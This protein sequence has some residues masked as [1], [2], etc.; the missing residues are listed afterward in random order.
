MRIESDKVYVY[1]APVEGSEAPFEA[2]RELAYEALTRLEL[3][4]PDEGEITLK[5]NATVLFPPEKRIITH[6]GF[7][8]GLIEALVEKGVPPQRMQVAELAVFVLVTSQDDLGGIIK[9]KMT[10]GRQ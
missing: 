6:P 4:L 10:P 7:L 9:T 3:D 5:P 2:Y 1:R 8:A